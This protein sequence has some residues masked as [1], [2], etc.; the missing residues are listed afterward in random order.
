MI[1]IILLLLLLCFVG[2]AV[3]IIG[4]LLAVLWPI[5]VILILGLVIDMLCLGKLF[6]KKNK[7]TE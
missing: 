1:T 2:L 4:G 3:L 7:K 5:A 6:K